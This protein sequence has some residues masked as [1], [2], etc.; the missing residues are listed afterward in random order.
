MTV[1]LIVLAVLSTVGGLVGVPYALSG[2]AIPNVF[3]RTLEPVIAHV[4]KKDDHATPGTKPHAATTN[5]ELDQL[6]A[7]T[8]VPKLGGAEPAEAAHEEHSPEEL[9]NE[10]LLAGLSVLLALSGIGIGIALF[11]KNP[12]RK[13]PKIL[14]EKWRVDEFYNGYIVDPLT[15]LSREGLWKGFDLG[16]IDGIVNGI[17]YFVAEAGKALRQIQVGFVRSYAAII[18]LGALVVLGYFIYYGL[19]LVG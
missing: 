16:F 14:E 2:G 15:S 8:E 13:L 1:P 11:G 17:G 4:G 6:Y 7:S 3:E 10:R 18:L 9:R 12:L 19:K 5:D